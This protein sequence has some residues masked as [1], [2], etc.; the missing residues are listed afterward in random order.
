ME[1][2]PNQSTTDREKGNDMEQQQDEF[3]QSLKNRK[4]ITKGQGTSEFHTPKQTHNISNP[5]T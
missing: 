4:Y 1:I 3:S 2:D 5:E